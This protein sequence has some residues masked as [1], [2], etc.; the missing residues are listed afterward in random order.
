M[1]QETSVTTS[2]RGPG[3]PR[4]NFEARRD[5]IIRTAAT[6]FAEKG[7]HAASTNDICAALKINRGVLYHYVSSKDEI[8]FAIHSRF[9]E[10]LLERARAIASAPEPADRIL[11]QLSRELLRT[12]AEY[13]AEVT[14]FLNEWRWL[15]IN[16]DLW[17]AVRQKRRKFE[18]IIERTIRVGIRD[19]IFESDSPRLSTLAFLG[20]HN[21]VYQWLR[22]GGRLTPDEISSH[23]VRLFFDG[24]RRSHDS[25]ESEAYKSHHGAAP[26]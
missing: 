14:V 18:R 12:I 7:F 20:T 25:E 26:V 8:L 9:I 11:I 3:R 4:V 1:A 16:E 19:G 5:E 23:F 17:P 2:K 24:I 21:F 13:R 22:E 10:P 15:A 6:P